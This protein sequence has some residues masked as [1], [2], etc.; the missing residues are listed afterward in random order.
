MP[1]MRLGLLALAGVIG[2]GCGTSAP[3]EPFFGEWKVTSTLAPGVSAAPATSAAG[4]VGREA[5]FSGRAARYG[6]SR[7]SGPT[8]THRWLAAATFTDAYRVAPTAIGVTSGQ[9]EFVDITCA[10]GALDHEG[11]L[12]V[13]PDGTLLTV[14]DGVFYVLTRQ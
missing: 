14:S 4:A 6:D 12:I 9:V 3:P 8:Y 7:C 11:M 2:A 1:A 13:R 10:S 5:G